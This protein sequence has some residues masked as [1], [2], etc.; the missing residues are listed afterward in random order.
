MT[1]SGQTIPHISKQGQDIIAPHTPDPRC[2]CFPVAWCN[3]HGA[4]LPCTCSIN[5]QP[6][7]KLEITFVHRDRPWKGHR[8]ATAS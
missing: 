7:W 2:Y 8:D 1:Y 3:Y 4:P 6:G 5:A